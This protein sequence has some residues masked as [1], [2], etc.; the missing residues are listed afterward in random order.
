LKAV[1]A[2]KNDYRG[3]REMNIFEVIFFALNAT[4]TYLASRWVYFHEGW[5]LA[6]IA[7]PLAFLACVGFWIMLGKIFI[8][9]SKPKDK[10][11]N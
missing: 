1:S 2:R 4:V 10:T 11:S 5:P 3:A 9:G 7:F 8:R 6:I